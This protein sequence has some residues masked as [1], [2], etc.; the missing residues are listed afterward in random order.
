MDFLANLSPDTY[1]NVMDQYRP[2][3]RAREHPGLGRRT[4]LGEVDEVVSYARS[5]GLRRVIH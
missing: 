1:V 5:I 3:Y 4:T 2:L